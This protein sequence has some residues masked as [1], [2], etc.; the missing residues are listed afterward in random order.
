MAG[1]RKDIQAILDQAED[2]FGS[3]IYVLAENLFLLSGIPNLNDRVY[4]DMDALSC[5]TDVE[6]W[7][8]KNVGLPLDT[9][10]HLSIKLKYEKQKK[11]LV[12]AEIESQSHLL[13]LANKSIVWKLGSENV[14]LNS[15]C[16][17]FLKSI[18]L[19]GNLLRQA[20]L[21]YGSNVVVEN[22]IPKSFKEIFIDSLKIIDVNS[23][24][25]WLKLTEKHWEK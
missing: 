21:L 3:N 18:A 17:L 8:L 23:I 15:N 19:Y 16:L 4:F 7:L 6:R 25:A 11:F 24:D 9:A 13:Q 20:M 12:I 14:F 1:S 10:P 22:K 2:L 5:M